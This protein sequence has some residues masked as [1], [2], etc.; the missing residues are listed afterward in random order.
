MYNKFHSRS[1]FLHLHRIQ[2]GV[3]RPYLVEN[4]N[5]CDY[6]LATQRVQ[7]H[8]ESRV[9]SNRIEFHIVSIELK[10]KTENEMNN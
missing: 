10:A 9:Q 1:S 7:A 2:G 8:L 6:H 5:Q 3:Y 4:E